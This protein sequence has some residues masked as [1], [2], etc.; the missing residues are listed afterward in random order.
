[1]FTKADQ[2]LFEHAARQHSVFTYQHAV[3]AGLSVA[4]VDRR[5]NLWERVHEGVFRIPGAIATWQSEFVAACLAATPPAAISHRSGAA[6]YELP[7]G[8]FDIVELS[9]LRWLRVQRPGIVVHESTR[10]CDADI[11]E[12]DGIPVVIPERLILELAGLKPNPNYVEML[13]HA[14]RRKRLITYDSTL[15]TFNR[16]ARRGVRGVKAMRI[17]LE[18]WNPE[19]RATESEM[20]TRLVQVMRRHGLP[21][22]VLQFEVTDRNGLFVARVDAALPQWR[23]TVDY[24]SKQEHSDEFQIA[25]DARRRDEIMGAGYWPLTA[26]HQDLVKG[27]ADLVERIRRVASNQPALL[28]PLTRR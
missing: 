18:R 22:P 20:E 16:L 2:A 4:Q 10:L 13:I 19:S 1:V 11:T 26:R 21:P 27:G 8:R 23:I 14:A 28:D 5:T 7:G 15:A 3:N 12:V 25:R 24:D 6:V 9:C 17:A